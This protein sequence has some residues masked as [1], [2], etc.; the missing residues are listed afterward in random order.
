MAGRA[1]QARPYRPKTI[2]HN[3][4][5][6]NKIAI[7]VLAGL[8]IISCT[9][10]NKEYDAMGVF[11][12]T[13]VIVSAEGNGKILSLDIKEGDRVEA[14]QEI[15]LIDTTQLYLTKLQLEASVR[16]TGSGHYN[17]SKQI[18]AL[19]QQLTKLYKERD[20]FT[21]LAAAGASGQKQVDDINAEI[22]VL[23]KQLA[24]QKDNL[25]NANKGISEQTVALEAQI[26]QVNDQIEK[27]RIKSPVSGTVLAKYAEAGELAGGGRALF[28]VANIDEVKLRA[29]ISADQLTD[30][31]LGQ[32]AKVYADQGEKGRREYAGKLTWIASEAE[33]TPKTIQTRDERS[34]LVYAVKVS[35]ENDGL[36]KLGMYGEVKF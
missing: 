23:E 15:G 11:E 2:K 21:K 30:L 10:K 25:Q 34:N 22:N 5:K 14:G 36:I 19:E 20:R 9:D 6:T 32:D 18:A 35:V 12:T 13:E 33:F 3:I 27:C 31:K 1:G 16:A 7:L 26:A 29:Y 4:M 8:S 28:K 24:A 17:I